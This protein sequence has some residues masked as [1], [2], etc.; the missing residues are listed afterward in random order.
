[1][2]RL[3]RPLPSSFHVQ[4]HFVEVQFHFH[5]GRLR[6]QDPVVEVVHVAVRSELGASS[7][8]LALVVGDAK[9]F[10]LLDAA[11]LGHVGR[12]VY[13][14]GGH[15]ALELHVACA[16]HGARERRH[17]AVHGGHGLQSQVLVGLER[18]KL[19]WHDVLTGARRH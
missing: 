2:A 15:A 7:R 1:M 14:R 5:A 17:A 9:L 8:L 6:R 4:L 19:T 16:K 18:A 12:H 10:K 3:L 11:A 13:F